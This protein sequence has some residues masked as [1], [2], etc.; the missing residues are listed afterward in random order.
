MNIASHADTDDHDGSGRS[1][2]SDAVSGVEEGPITRLGSALEVPQRKAGD[3]RSDSFSA[4][5][6]RQAAELISA[7]CDSTCLDRARP[8]EKELESLVFECTALA[9]GTAPEHLARVAA[10]IGRAF[11]AQLSGDLAGTDWKTPLRAICAINYFFSKGSVAK[12]IAEAVLSQ[13]EIVE[14]LRYFAN[15][16]SCREEALRALRQHAEV[17]TS[18][19]EAARLSSGDGAIA[20]VSAC[21]TVAKKEIPE[22]DDD[23]IDGFSSLAETSD[24]QDEACIASWSSPVD[25]VIDPIQRPASDTAGTL[26]G[27]ADDKMESSSTGLVAISADPEAS[28][29]ETPVDET[30]LNCDETLDGTAGGDGVNVA[31]SVCDRVA[32]ETKNDSQLALSPSAKAMLEIDANTTEDSSSL[33]ETNGYQDEPCIPSW[34]SIC[35]ELNA[36]TQCPTSDGVAEP[37]STLAG[38]SHDAAASLTI[39]ERCRLGLFARQCHPQTGL[40]HREVDWMPPSCGSALP[41]TPAPH[42]RDLSSRDCSPV[43]PADIAIQSVG[44]AEHGVQDQCMAGHGERS[45]H[46]DLSTQSQGP[47]KPSKRVPIIPWGVEDTI[48]ELSDVQ[49][50]ADLVH[51]ALL[52]L[53][54]QCVKSPCRAGAGSESID[55]AH[56]PCRAPEVLQSSNDE[57]ES[58]GEGRAEVSS[59]SQELVKARRHVPIIPW[60]AELTIPDMQEV[61]VVADLVR[62]AISD[63]GP[64][65]R[66]GECQELSRADTCRTALEAPR[67]SVGSH[68]VIGHG[69][70]GIATLSKEPIQT[71]RHVPIIPWGVELT[72]SDIPE[73]AVAGD[74]VRDALSNL[75]SPA[76]QANGLSRLEQSAKRNIT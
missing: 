76:P 65:S 6:S 8:K 5:D 53:S 73:V 48:P 40:A 34:S 67:S 16:V 63:L 13:P 55:C 12:E 33:V 60:G 35:D 32:R 61:D 66:T 57:S 4:V 2:C 29:V 21:A 30:P 68:E 44:S 27:L 56:A 54:P 38:P 49:V 24:D 31:V 15:E 52:D 45:G 22:V 10:A 23:T 59:H 9:S 1:D 51:D 39:P 42:P 46:L 72:L 50:A 37:F 58:M 62:D 14:L 64:V 28:L 19:N 47:V 7:F 75:S 18:G 11:Q 3:I 20:T 25:E 69:H 26:L 74:L 70:L 41:R 43:D 17:S 71:R 36:D